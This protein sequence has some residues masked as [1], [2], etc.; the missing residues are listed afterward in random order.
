MGCATLYVPM[1]TGQSIQWTG[2]R[3]G[4]GEQENPEASPNGITRVPFESVGLG[5][6][7]HVDTNLTKNKSYE[8]NLRV[9]DQ[10]VPSESRL[11]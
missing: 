7:E 5:M 10:A 8:S 6:G 1:R 11:G 2:R 3:E 9:N 4:F